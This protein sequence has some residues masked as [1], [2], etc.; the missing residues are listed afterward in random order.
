MEGI[1]KKKTHVSDL[2]ITGCQCHNRQ[3]TLCFCAGRGAGRSA[4]SSAGRSA[5][6]SAGTRNVVHFCPVTPKKY[7][8]ALGNHKTR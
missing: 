2:P 8:L 3:V 6:S 4:G 5:R 7:E 1:N